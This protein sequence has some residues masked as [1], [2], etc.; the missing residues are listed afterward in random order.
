MT[1]HFQ[2]KLDSETVR[3]L[4]RKNCDIHWTVDFDNITAHS[5]RDEILDRLEF[6][7]YCT[8]VTEHSVTLLFMDREVGILEFLVGRQISREHVVKCTGSSRGVLVNPVPVTV[9]ITFTDEFDKM[10]F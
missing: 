8:R 7:A 2:C 6:I 10:Y 5:Y 9:K 3:H 1:L 4:D